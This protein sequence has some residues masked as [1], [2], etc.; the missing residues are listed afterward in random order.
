ML[1]YGTAWNSMAEPKGI[2]WLDNSFIVGTR[3]DLAPTPL[4]QP[5]FT[6]TCGNCETATY[7]E[8]E[9]P[10]DVPILCNVCAANVAKESEEDEDTLLLYDFPADLKAR[11]IDLAYQR[12]LPVEAVFKDFLAWKLGRPTNAN[13]YTKTARKKAKE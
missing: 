13:L 2:T 10:A 6:A 9:Y 12:R 11:L 3:A 7:T 4:P 5:I 8:A 1:Y